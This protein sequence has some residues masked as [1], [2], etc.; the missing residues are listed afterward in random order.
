MNKVQ[1][2]TVVLTKSHFRLYFQN[3]HLQYRKLVPYRPRQTLNQGFTVHDD[4]T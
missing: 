1:R 4:Q 2:Y 3:P